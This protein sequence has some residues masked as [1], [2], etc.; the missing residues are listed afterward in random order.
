MAVTVFFTRDMKMRKTALLLN[1]LLLAACSRADG[2]DG[3]Y[4]RA[5]ALPFEQ[6]HGMARALVVS[7]N[8]TSMVLQSAWAATPLSVSPDGDGYVVLEDNQPAYRITFNGDTAAMLDLD[9]AAE[10]ADATV[11]EFRKGEAK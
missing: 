4:K 9:T 3:E 11:Y 5:N 7:G 8:G 2:I 10:G 1:L 6:E